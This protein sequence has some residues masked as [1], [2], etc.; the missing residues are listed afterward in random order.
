MPRAGTDPEHHPGPE[1]PRHH[2]RVHLHNSIY[3]RQNHEHPA[4]VEQG[5]TLPHRAVL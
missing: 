1:H 4:G 5:R 2:L 3:A